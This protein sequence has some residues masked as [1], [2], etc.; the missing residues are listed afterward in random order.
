[1]SKI[2]RKLTSDWKEEVWY[3]TVGYCKWLVTTDTMAVWWEL[4]SYLCGWIQY[5]QVY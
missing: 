4:Y 5:R 2:C 3:K 1:M